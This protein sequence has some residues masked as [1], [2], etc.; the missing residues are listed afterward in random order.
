MD[1]LLIEAEK[2]IDEADAQSRQERVESTARRLKAI[3]DEEVRTA[4][5]RRVKA[6]GEARVAKMYET[7]A[8]AVTIEGH[9]LVVRI[10]V[11][12]PDLAVS[13]TAEQAVKNVQRLF[14]HRFQDQ[15][16]QVRAIKAFDPVAWRQRIRPFV[17]DEL[18][19]LLKLAPQLVSIEELM[20]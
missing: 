17:E 11:A 20:R 1:E 19:Q 18:R 14:I 8:P 3:K 9:G 4:D 5:V 7:S 15:T 10:T 13:Q 6:A 12:H 2:L 16:G